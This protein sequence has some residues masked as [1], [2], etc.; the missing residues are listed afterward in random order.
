LPILEKVWRK[1][2]CLQDYT[3]SKGHTEGIAIA[4]QYFDP[5]VINRVLFSNCGIDGD[6]FTDIL[7]GLAKLDDVK[8]ITYKQNILN[9]EAVQ[10]LDPILKKR[11]PRNLE[12]LKM[13][14][15]KASSAIN[16]ELI[17]KIYTGS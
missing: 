6:E 7:N 17:N 10:A 14:D 9:L 4:C 13:I 12:E 5:K 15:V 2:L 11:L 16:D 1:T 8:S 3:L